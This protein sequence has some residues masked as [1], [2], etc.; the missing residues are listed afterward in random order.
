MLCVT[1]LISVELNQG[2][3][4]HDQSSSAVGAFILRAWFCWHNG[5]I[6]G[7]QG[8]AATAKG[9]R[10]QGQDQDEGSNRS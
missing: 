7:A 8:I 1:S 4:W 6:Q 5:A 3:F 10:Q 2:G 9:G